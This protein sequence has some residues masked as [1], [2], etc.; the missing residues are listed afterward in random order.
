MKLTKAD[1][2]AYPKLLHYVKNDLPKVMKIPKIV[3][4]LGKYGQIRKRT[5]SGVL[6]Y[7]TEPTIKVTP[8]VSACGEFTPNIKSNE[9]RLHK[10]LVEKFEASRGDKML[11][12]TVGATILH[13][14]AHW[15]DDQDSKDYPGEEG[16]LFEKKVYK[17]G[18]HHCA[19]YAT[20]LMKKGV[21][22]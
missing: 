19:Y 12:M 6:K 5:L 2:K 17:L 14:L 1:E 7:G 13:E 18:R 9:L 3:R 22:F 10:S 4:A 15:A 16:E 11:L 20:D 8:L 21:V